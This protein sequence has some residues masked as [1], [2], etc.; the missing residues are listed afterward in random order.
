MSFS[1]YA[2]SYDDYDRLVY[3]DHYDRVSTSIGSEY[4]ILY[5]W[6]MSLCNYLGLSFQEFRYVTAVITLGG[7]E[8]AAIKLSPQKN[9]VWALY[10]IYS[11]C[12]DATLIRASLSMGLIAIYIVRLIN[13]K[14]KKDYLLCSI[15]VIAASLIHSSS[16]AYCSF[17]PLWIF[18]KN[19]SNMTKFLCI[20]LIVVGFVFVG[21]SII[22][23][24]YGNL[25]VREYTLE[26]YTSADS[27]SLGDVIY[28]II[29][30][31]FIISPAVIFGRSG[32]FKIKDVQDFDKSILGLNLLFMILLIPQYYTS[33]FSRLFKVLIFFNYIFLTR[34]PWQQSRSAKKPLL[35]VFS[36]LYAIIMFSFH[37]YNS[38]L[39]LI[40]V[41]DMHV[42]T[43]EILNFSFFY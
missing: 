40:F 41:V 32:S 3:M 16:W 25:P 5:V 7:L 30:Y 8:Y 26:K 43:N 23:T 20:F 15:W 27:G 29:K 42:K 34:H 6:I 21:S 19:R 17:I 14:T 36:L 37:I 2:L 39:S 22:F 28:N 10:L 31:C 24:V 1:L 18:L 11:S 35:I 33:L 4:E 38:P 12:F 13:S 9:Q